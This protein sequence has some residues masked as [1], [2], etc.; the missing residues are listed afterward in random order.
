MSIL[1]MIGELGNGLIAAY[2]VAVTV[3]LAVGNVALWGLG[4]VAMVRRERRRRQRQ[5]DGDRG[6]ET[7][8]ETG[9][10]T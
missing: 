2:P 10:G 7:E 3:G 6:T 1:Y 5:R 9:R 4:T 8:T